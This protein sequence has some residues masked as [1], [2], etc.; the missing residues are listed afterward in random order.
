MTSF[1]PTKCTTP[2]NYLDRRGLDVKSSA[3]VVAMN[4]LQFTG[5]A[6]VLISHG[7]NGYGALTNAGAY[8]SSPMRGIAGTTLEDPNRNLATLTIPAAAPPQFMS[9]N[10]S[11]ANDATIYFD[12][13]VVRPMVM[14]VISK[15]QL[16][17]RTH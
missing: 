5:A 15:A 7:E 12:D 1:D 10:Y 11:D 2:Q 3:T 16:G 13:I 17:P 14:S 6:F 9:A 8:R 4:Y